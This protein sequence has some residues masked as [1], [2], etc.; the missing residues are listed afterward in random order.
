MR[1]AWLYTAGMPLLILV[2]MLLAQ[3]LAPPVELAAKS[4]FNVTVIRVGRSPGPVSIGKLT[5]A[6]HQDIVVG[7]CDDGTVS[8]LLGDGRGNFH[9]APGSPF[10][11]NPNPNDIAIADMNGDGIPDLVIAN[12]QT[13]YLTVLLGD[14]RGS[15]RQASK[16]PFATNSKPH[17]HGV[18]VGDF[19]GN[20]KP[21]VV[22]DSWGN[23]RILLFATDG[24]GNLI[25]PGRSFA[26]DLHTDSGV[27]AADFERNGHLDIVTANQSAGTVGLL[28]G[29]GHG[30]FRK[31]PGSPYPAGEQAWQFAV[32][33]VNGDGNADVLVIPYERDLR[34]R[35]Q[36]DVR[37]LLGGRRGGLTPR[38]GSKLS[39]DGCA[40][41]TRVAIGDVNSDRYADI[42][43]SCAENNRLV[44][45][46]GSHSGTFSRMVI[47]VPTG[48]GGLAIGDLRSAG[49]AS[50]VVANN[51]RGTITILTS[52]E[53]RY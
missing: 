45:F 14:G 10:A 41:P 8:V 29:N 51:N 20:R 46:L 38:R 7:N 50:I 15:F 12:T 31:A 26:A 39:L 6:G 47:D 11:S 52:K 43:V 4:K 48:W 17:P 28:L 21:A 16:S 40:G 34:D 22:T 53:D 35:S 44:E 23:N 42:V 30:G 2:A 32:G 33:D 13:P 24:E 19:L 18:A 25:L 27:A 49:P 9:S 37:I 36:L 3:A 5:R 1:V